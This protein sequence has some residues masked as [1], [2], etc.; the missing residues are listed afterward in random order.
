MPDHRFH[1]A[2]VLL[3]T[4]A[5]A[6][7]GQLDAA[8]QCAQLK[9]SLQ[10]LVCYDRV[11]QAGDA[12]LAPAA[13][14]A[15]PASPAV[16]TPPGP[17]AAATLGEKS[18]ARSSRKPDDTGPAEPTSLEAKVTRLKETRQ[19]VYRIWLDDGQVWEQMEM[20][21]LFQVTEG[22]TVRIEKGKMGGYQ[23]ARVSNGRSGWVRVVRIN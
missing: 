2:L 1:W 21:S 19:N 22:D 16:A 14:S 18:L 10:R 4:L 11:F 23:M 13:G 5:V 3:P 15:L 6:A 9:D 20:A 7:D 12:A 17:A 8:R